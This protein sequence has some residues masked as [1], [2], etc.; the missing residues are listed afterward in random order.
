MHRFKYV[1]DLRGDLT[2]GNFADEI[3]FAPARYFFVL[4]VPGS[5]VRG[6]HA[7]HAC[8]QFLIAACGHVSV[9]VDE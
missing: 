3:P 2:V 5:E 1:R 4:N 7:H 6:E 8:H 9:M